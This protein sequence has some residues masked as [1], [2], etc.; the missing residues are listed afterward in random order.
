M[1]GPN[2]FWCNS[3]PLTNTS[4]SR[5]RFVIMGFSF[6]RGVGEMHEAFGHRSES[7]MEKTFSN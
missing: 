6:E 7:I 2:A 1:A 4:M 3:Q 5:R